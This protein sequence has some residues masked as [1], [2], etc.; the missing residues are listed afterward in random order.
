MIVLSFSHIYC[1]SI[2][3]R[4]RLRTGVGVDKILPTPAPTPTPVKTV[5]SDRF[6]LRL[7]LRLRSPAQ[8]LQGGNRTL[9]AKTGHFGW[10]GS[11]Q[12]FSYMWS[13]HL[14]FDVFHAKSVRWVKTEMLFK[15]CFNPWL[16]TD[17][18]PLFALLELLNSNERV[19]R[20]GNVFSWITS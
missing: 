13:L 7:R 14:I 6:Q 12:A 5:D 11:L 8:D 10:L 16:R 9:A 3:H 17:I 1:L 20:Q 4:R 19:L 2:T 15:C 18:S